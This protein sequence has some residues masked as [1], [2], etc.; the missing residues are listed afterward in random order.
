MGKIKY[1]GAYIVPLLGILAFSTTGIY[2]FFGL[3]FLYVIVPILE[4]VIPP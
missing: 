1:F 4:I 3:I 2:A